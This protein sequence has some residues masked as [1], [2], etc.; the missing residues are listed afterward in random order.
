ML[1][2]RTM[3]IKFVKDPKHQSGEF[4]EAFSDETSVID[5]EVV[6]YVGDA[7]VRVVEETAEVLIGALAAYMFMD[8]CR[9]VIVI[10]ASK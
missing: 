4:G 1:K 9:K 10:W 3:Q 8:T 6:D 7:V 5:P 2:N